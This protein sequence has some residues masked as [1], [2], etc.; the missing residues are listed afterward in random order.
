MSEVSGS[1]RYMVITHPTTN[2]D[3]RCLTT[4]K[5]ATEHWSLSLTSSTSHDSLNI[6]TPCAGFE[7]TTQQ[8]IAVPR[9]NDNVKGPTVVQPPAASR[10]DVSVDVQD[11]GRYE[12]LPL[13][14]FVLA[15]L[16]G[17]RPSQ[18]FAPPD[19]PPAD[20][21]SVR[22]GLRRV[23][24]TSKAMEVLGHDGSSNDLQSTVRRVENCRETRGNCASPATGRHLTAL[25]D[26]FDAEQ[27][28]AICSSVK[29]AA[30]RRS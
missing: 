15:K 7:V 18:T 23:Y 3:R 30:R 1:L 13:R 25:K 10:N 27:R 14:T 17:Q 24:S 29:M 5:P 2:R 28:A 20:C 9:L 19:R 6:L 26:R 12:Q 21:S 4:V 8:S 16:T 22:D 11:I